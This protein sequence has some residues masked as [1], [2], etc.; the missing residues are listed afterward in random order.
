MTD[1]LNVVGMYAVSI[2]VVAIAGRLIRRRYV[3]REQRSLSRKE[4]NPA[5]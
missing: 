2:F 1:Y 4:S 3:Q 5:H